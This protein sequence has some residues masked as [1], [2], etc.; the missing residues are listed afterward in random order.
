MRTFLICRC[1]H[2]FFHVCSDLSFPS[3]PLLHFPPLHTSNSWSCYS[4]EAFLNLLSSLCSSNRVLSFCQAL[5]NNLFLFLLTN[6]DLF[7]ST[8]FF[9]YSPSF[10]WSRLQISQEKEVGNSCYINQ[11]RTSLSC[12]DQSVLFFSHSYYTEFEVTDQALRLYISDVFSGTINLKNE[13]YMF[14]SNNLIFHALKIFKISI[15]LQS[16]GY[17]R[18]VFNSYK[19]L[20]W[21]TL[22]QLC[23]LQGLTQ[24]LLCCT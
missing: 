24:I 15:I 2:N 17:S 7:F 21:Q 5:T 10:L 22:T 23:Y 11:R 3:L 9:F 1:F 14:S 20:V 6:I 12:K 8:E 18:S 16:Q 13:N 19:T 4:G